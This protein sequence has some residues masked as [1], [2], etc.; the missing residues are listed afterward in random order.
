MH[1]FYRKAYLF[2]NIAIQY[3][4]AKLIQRFSLKNFTLLVDKNS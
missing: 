2:I 4:D 1:A 3:Q